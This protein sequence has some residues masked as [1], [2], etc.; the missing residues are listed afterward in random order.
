MICSVATLPSSVGFTLGKAPSSVL[1]QRRLSPQTVS[2]PRS[3]LCSCSVWQV[4]RAALQRRPPSS[5]GSF[6]PVTAIGSIAANGCFVPLSGQWDPTEVVAP[7]A[8]VRFE[9]EADEQLLC[10]SSCSLSL[11]QGSSGNTL[12]GLRDK[13]DGWGSPHT[14]GADEASQS[15]PRGECGQ[16]SEDHRR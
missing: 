3:R 15:G 8:K 11:M 7:A 9:P 13:S 6:G 12:F 10:L 16:H 2:S 5:N 4:R 14:H 1:F